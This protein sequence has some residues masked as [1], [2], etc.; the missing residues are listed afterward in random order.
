[1]SREVGALVLFAALLTGLELV[2]PRGH[3]PPALTAPFA[4]AGCVAIVVVAKALGT[5]W[6]QRPEAPDE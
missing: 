2:F 4:L 5:R 1:M 3:V 6:L